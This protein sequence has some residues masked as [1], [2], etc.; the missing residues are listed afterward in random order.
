MNHESGDSRTLQ[1]SKFYAFHEERLPG[2][3]KLLA[4]GKGGVHTR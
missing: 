4:K 1:I 2:F 3:H